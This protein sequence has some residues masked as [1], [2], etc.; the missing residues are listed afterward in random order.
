MAYPIKQNSIT[1]SLIRKPSNPN[2]LFGIKAGAILYCIAIGEEKWGFCA[3]VKIFD[4][5]LLF[6][7]SCSS[8]YHA[9][10]ILLEIY[11]Q[12]PPKVLEHLHDLHDSFLHSAP[13]PPPYQCFFVRKISFMTFS[14][15]LVQSYKIPSENNIVFRREEGFDWK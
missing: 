15:C 14:L 8:A 9:L 2:F 7:T 5:H 11:L 4:N 1:M 10:E 3:R 12:S 13:F 6:R